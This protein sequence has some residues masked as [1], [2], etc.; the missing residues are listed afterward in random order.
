MRESYVTRAGSSCNWHLL[1]AQAYRQATD[2]WPNCARSI[3][4]S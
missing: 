1:C 4:L 2:G 3:M